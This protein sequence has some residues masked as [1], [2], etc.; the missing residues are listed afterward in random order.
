MLRETSLSTGLFLFLDELMLDEPVI[1]SLG[2]P[3]ILCFKSVFLGGILVSMYLI[4]QPMI[5]QKMFLNALPHFFYPLPRG[6]MC[7][8]LLLNFSQNL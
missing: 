2:M 5:D 7:D 6:P 3:G 8:G 1:Q 4:D